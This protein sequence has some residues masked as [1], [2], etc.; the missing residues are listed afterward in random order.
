M[1][2]LQSAQTCRRM[3]VI[4]NYFI[5]LFQNNNMIINTRD[6]HLRPAFT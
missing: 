2:L 1:T 4:E 6:T 5:Q 3:T